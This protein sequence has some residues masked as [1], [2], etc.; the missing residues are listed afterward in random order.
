MEEKKNA[1]KIGTALWFP[2]DNAANLYGGARRRGWAR[3][4]RLSVVL[5]ET[6][7]PELL[8]QALDDVCVR[9]PTFCAA[10]RSGMFWNYFERVQSKAIVRKET[11]FPGRPINTEH[12]TQPNF[13]ILYYLRRVTLEV[14]HGMTDGGGSVRFLASLIARYYELQG[15]TIED[16]PIILRTSDSPT[17]EET[18]DPFILNSKSD[19]AAKNYIKADVYYEKQP[20]NRDY[21]RLTHGFC[22]VED[23]KAA[24]SRYALTITEYL[25]AVLIYS[26]I[27]T[28]PKPID[29]AI[30]I[31]IPLDL[32][33]RFGTESVR[34]FCYMTDISFHPHGRRD[35]P[36][37][38]ICESIAG[39]LQSNATLEYLTTEIS[40][41]VRAQQSPLLR[42]VPYPLKHVFLRNTYRKNQRSFTTFLSNIG[43]FNTPPALLS[44]IDRAEFTLGE[45]P[46]NPFGV[47][48]V[49]VN[50]LL[51]ITFN[52]CT[53]NTEKQRCVFRFLTS[54]GVAMRV[55][56][57]RK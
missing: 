22:R 19:I 33:R 31:S 9:F 53:D 48:L 39:M 44:H 13:R 25:T 3:T 28:A 34:N 11:D 21:M 16:S 23:L 20:W 10:V 12:T 43:D 37:S 50:G 6:V 47:G 32:R 4:L 29:K 17:E 55:E 40:Q 51:T 57:N 27:Q 24:A 38:E 41:N 2:V 52:D 36:F 46:F 30:S 42:A 7:K 18:E 49:S 26:Y 8:Q 15:E 45:T 56:S 35:V 1:P 14:F 5:N 54:Q